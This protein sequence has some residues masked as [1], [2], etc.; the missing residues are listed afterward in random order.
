MRPFTTLATAAVL[1]LLAGST[2]AGPFQDTEAALRGVY[3]QYRVALFATNTGN[4]AKSAEAIAAFDKG[5]TGLAAQ[6]TAAPQYADDPAV[7]ATLAAVTSHAA[8][9]AEAVA[10]G[11][12]PEAHEALEG[13]RAEI[14]SLH[15]RNGISTFSDRMNAYHATMEEVLAVD[16]AKLDAAGME[17]LAE[18]VGVLAYWATDIATN[19]AP[20]AADPAYQPLADAF[21]A[22]VASIVQAVRAGDT[23]AIT[24]ALPTLKPAYSKF[25]VQ[26][27]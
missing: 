24:A 21:Q 12:L 15:A 19:P 25:F 10:A 23:A 3:G 4:A 8:H 7:P 18:K 11:N 13:I 22:S 27:G 14:G 6:I 20:E 1:S 5:W 9:A 16:P 26:F 17:M 2:L